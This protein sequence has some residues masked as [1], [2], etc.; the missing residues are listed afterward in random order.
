MPSSQM[1]KNALTRI[2]SFLAFGATTIFLFQNCGKAGFQKSDSSSGAMAG[3][4]SSSSTGA[5]AATAAAF[6][7]RANLNQISYMSC[8]AAGASAADSLDP[9][10]VPFYNV[11]AGAYDNYRFASTFGLTGMSDSELRSRLVAGVGL[12]SEFND[13]ID[14]TYRKPTGDARKEAMALAFQ[15]SPYKNYQLATGLI[16]ENNH[17]STQ[18]GDFGFSYDL[19]SGV[20]S[21]LG[22][23]LMQTQF[24]KQ[25]ILSDKNTEMQSFVG[26]LER[27]Q[28][29]ITSSFA[30]GVSE[31]DQSSF[32]SQLRGSLIMAL[33][34]TNT[35]ENAEIT[36]FLSPLGADEKSISKTLYGRGYKLDFRY[37]W[38]G[39][40]GI[41][42]PTLFAN[43]VQELDLTTQDQSKMDI[44][45]QEN[46]DWD[47][48]ALR[49]VRHNDRI[50]PSNKRPY[51]K[52]GTTEIRTANNQLI[53]G[54]HVACPTQ[55]VGE[56]DYQDPDTR[57][58]IKRGINNELNNVRLQM[59]RRFLPAE[60]WEINTDPDYLCAV[61]TDMAMGRGKCYVS[62]DKDYSKY[63]QY[64]HDMAGQMPCGQG[65]NECPA[66]VSICY[67]KK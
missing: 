60:M 51:I 41:Q 8:P 35:G 9:F 46:Q 55:F 6:P 1:S 14:L 2:A 48:F 27:G 24:F 52:P 44:S 10:A 13:F 50:D 66:Y 18:E 21:T 37:E 56:N 54:V 12:T 20:L 31:V 58:I 61:P 42:M 38:P 49:I 5:A 30:F 40:G 25:T 29:A 19:M 26:T 33:G 64:D 17:R 4:F 53:K 59:A 45:T 11:R 43:G 23:T 62:G 16:N 34:Y 22:D 67:R 28:Q 47:C 39:T 15:N 32:S 57:Q 3:A 65:G 63:I 7:Y 36:Q